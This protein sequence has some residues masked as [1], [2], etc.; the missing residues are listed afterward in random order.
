MYLKSFLSLRLL[1]A[2]L[3]NTK[4]CKKLKRMT[5]TLVNGYSSDS[6]QQELSNENQHDRIQMVI[7]NFCILV[8]WTKVA[9]ALEGWSDYVELISEYCFS[10]LWLP[11]S[12]R[13]SAGCRRR[14]PCYAGSAGVIPPTPTWGSHLPWCPLPPSPA[15][16]HTPCR[17]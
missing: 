1:V 14:R 10:Y 12:V 17:S 4:C 15:P 2:N 11:L 5:Q 16:T 8:L 3:A 7:H 6:T 13:W 9:W